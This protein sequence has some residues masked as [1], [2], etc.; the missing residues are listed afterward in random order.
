M[1]R[2]MDM[3]RTLNRLTALKIARTNTNGLYADGGGLYLRVKGG[4]RGWVF[5]FT[6][7]GR[8]REMG[9]GAAH[10]LTLAE[11]REKARESRKL[12]LQGVDP[13]EQRKQ[14][15]T[16]A[17]LEQAK[18][19]TFELAAAAL[20]AA[21]VS[22]WTNPKH[23]AAWPRTLEQYAY[24]MIGKLPVK[25]IDTA[26]VTKVLQP[27]WQEKTETASRLRGRIEAVLDWATVSGFRTGDN[28]A[29]WSGHLAH[30]FSLKGKAK[31]HFAAL[32]YAEMPAFMVKLRVDSSVQARALEFL[33][34]TGARLEEVRA[35]T[36]DE[37]DLADKV[38]TVPAKRMKAR[39]PHRV[40]LCD[41]AMAVLAQMKEQQRSAYI[42]AGNRVG[43]PLGPS[44][45]LLLAKALAEKE[46]TLHGFR[47]AFRTWAAER[48]NYPREV[49]ELALAHNVSSE[50]ER[51]YQRSDMVEKRR[52]FMAAWAG[53]LAK[54]QPEGKVL[55]MR[56]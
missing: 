28:P 18:G 55:P 9:L 30:V 35:A 24:P 49:A 17:R 43:R 29:R 5:R 22:E 38:W 46:I 52:Q 40:P 48:T 13:I 20:I 36:W 10:T 25:D 42:F 3:A 31:Q 2:E 51:A 54:P 44:T 15:H 56:A 41:A 53:F 4:S 39:K 27:I 1:G 34:L 47:S 26:L 12:L 45:L 50:V 21:K 37:I 8:K 33:I 6:L 11:A 14:E 32:P 19:M 23:R 7:H 16:A